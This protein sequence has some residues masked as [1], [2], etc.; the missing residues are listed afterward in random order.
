MAAN[1]TPLKI[2]IGAKYYRMS[3]ITNEIVK[4]INSGDEDTLLFFGEFLKKRAELCDAPPSLPLTHYIFSLLGCTAEPKVY[5]LK[6][7]Y[8][9]TTVSDKLTAIGF[10]M[11]VFGADYTKQG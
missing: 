7:L 5:S 6:E 4:S 8:V 1:H 11:D 10:N 9:R 2:K 3:D